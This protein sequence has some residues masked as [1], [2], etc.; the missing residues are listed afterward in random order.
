MQ[1]KLFPFE[2]AVSCTVLPLAAPILT[3][4]RLH[5]S[6]T[7]G[8]AHQRVLATVSTNRHMDKFW[9]H[10]FDDV[11]APTPDKQ[12][13]T[14]VCPIFFNCFSLSVCNIH[15]QYSFYT[16][17]H[18]VCFYIRGMFVFIILECEWLA[19]SAFWAKQ[20][21]PQLLNFS[22]PGTHFADGAFHLP[23]DSDFSTGNDVAFQLIVFQLQVGKTRRMPPLLWYAFIAQT[24]LQ[25]HTLR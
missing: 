20:T 4:N 1:C 8:P 22:A 25:Q 24:S 3:W 11:I 7:V 16:N 5:C 2:H 21:L 15:I 12:S 23:Q 6:S 18:C 13:L 14:P 9:W 19:L 10:D 17:N